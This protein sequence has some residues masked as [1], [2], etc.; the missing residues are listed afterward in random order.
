VALP[1]ALAL[2]LAFALAFMDFGAI[3]HAMAPISGG[4]GRCWQK[5]ACAQR[6]ANTFVLQYV[7]YMFTHTMHI[8][9][10]IHSHTT[11]TTSATT[12]RIYLHTPHNT[13]KHIPH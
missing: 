6:N 1:L 3:A 10:H 9:S 5:C 2:G 11:T 13:P 12:H 8:S 4:K 7:Y